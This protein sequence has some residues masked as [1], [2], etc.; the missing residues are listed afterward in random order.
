[1]IMG[2]FEKCF[3]DFPSYIY[4]VKGGSNTIVNRPSTQTKINNVPEIKAPTA[5]KAS[6]VTNAWD[7]YLGSNTTNIHPITAQ[8][9]PNRIF[10]TDATRSIRLGNHEMK[11]FWNTISTG[12]K[13]EKIRNKC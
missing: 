9:D 8:P 4:A 3:Q 13:Q 7:G 10:S 5:I 1:M 12:W 6:D 2:S 11:S